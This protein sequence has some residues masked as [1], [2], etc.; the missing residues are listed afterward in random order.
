MLRCLKSKVPFQAFSGASQNGV[1]SPGPGTSSRAHCGAT[2]RLG[3]D[4]I[5]IRREPWAVARHEQAKRAIGTALATLEGVQ[6]HLEPLIAGTQRRN[7]IRITGSASSGLSSEDIDITIVS[8]ASA[9]SQ[10]AMLPFVTTE[11]DSVAERTAK[12]IQKPLNSVARE[13]RRRHPSS[14]RPFRPFVLS[15]G[16]T[17]ETKARDALKLWKSIM[18]GGVYSLLVRRLSLGL[19]RARARCFEL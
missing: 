18:T 7:D 14:D 17:M 3:H 4:E 15:L 11:D 9:N 19:L 16:G 6:V 2:N 10:T 12:L 8:L 13:K 5:C 1:I